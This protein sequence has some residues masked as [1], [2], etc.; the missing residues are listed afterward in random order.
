[1]AGGITNAGC[2]TIAV[3]I[4]NGASTGY[5]SSA[6]AYLAVGSASTAFA[7]TQT[8]LQEASNKERN[9]MVAGYPTV[10]NQVI[11]FRSLWAAASANFRWNEIGVFNAATGGTMLCRDVQALGEKLNTQSWQ[12]TLAITIQPD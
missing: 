4:T 2:S 10:S 1:M 6:S 11:T 3:L 8:D 5:F 7:A 12:L 9:A